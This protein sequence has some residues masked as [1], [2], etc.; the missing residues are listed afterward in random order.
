MTYTPLGDDLSKIIESYD[1]SKWI[2][3]HQ[4]ARWNAEGRRKAITHAM[5]GKDHP[6]GL[7]LL[8]EDGYDGQPIGSLSQR[9]AESFWNYN[10]NHVFPPEVD[11]VRFGIFMHLDLYRLLALVLKGQWEE[12]FAREVCGWRANT[13]K[14]LVIALRDEDAMREAV[15]RFNPDTKRLLG[16]L[17][18]HG[19]IDLRVA[20]KKSPT[21]GTGQGGESIQSLV[22]SA[23]EGALQSGV[24]WVAE[25]RY[26]PDAFDTLVQTMLLNQLHWMAT[27]SRE[28]EEF[29]RHSI[30]EV[31]LSIQGTEEER[32]RYWSLGQARVQLLMDLDELRLQVESAR[33]QASSIAYQY[34]SVFGEA[35][36][37]L[38]E[39]RFRYYE[40]EQKILLKH[41]NPGLSREELDE[42]IKQKIEE[43]KAEVARLREDTRDAA[44]MVANRSLLDMLVGSGGA[45][46]PMP[47]EAI[48]QLKRKCKKILREI[49]LLIHPDRLK[50]DPAY[51]KLTPEQK[52]KL[53]EILAEALK[54]DVDELGYSGRFIESRF[55][56]PAALERALIEVKFHLEFAGINLDP[57]LEIQGET[58]VERLSWLEKEIGRLERDLDTAKVELH[59]MVIDEEAQQKRDLLANEA[60]HAE[61]KAAMKEQTAEY[62]KKADEL[63]AEL[64]SLLAGDGE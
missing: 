30:E 45:G 14:D 55:R 31:I 34:L 9:S 44:R 6:A 49:F 25:A 35:E 22:S 56:T 36:I 19:A 16:R 47:D 50:N 3:Q 39:S 58:L 46:T 18:D 5:L 48:E 62:E 8:T 61:I 26:S 41:A 23:L 52:A 21:F 17:L 42:Q 38:R 59:A 40:L 54:V 7:R 13:G 11:L 32:Q 12:F 24:G 43:L 37:A 53:S 33:L 1:D 51:E 28:L 64:E 15:N 10:D 57:Q 63:A 29:R 60:K 20:G 27:D 4:R 2:T